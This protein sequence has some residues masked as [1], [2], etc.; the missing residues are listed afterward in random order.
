MELVARMHLDLYR[1]L[2]DAV[3]GNARAGALG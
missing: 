2:A 3:H 1:R